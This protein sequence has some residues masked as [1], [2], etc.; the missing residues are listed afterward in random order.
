[1]ADFDATDC[2][3]CSYWNDRAGRC[4]LPLQERL[5]QLRDGQFR[6]PPPAHRPD[7]FE[8]ESPPL[9]KKPNFLLP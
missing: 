2:K 6:V 1:M 7:V 3:G 9:V 4:S 5:C 8:D